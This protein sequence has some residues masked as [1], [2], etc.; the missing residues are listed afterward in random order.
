MGG[1]SFPAHCRTGS[2]YHSPPPPQKK[3]YFIGTCFLGDH[4]KVRLFWS[5][6]ESCLRT[7]L[8]YFD[9]KRAFSKTSFWRPR[10]TPQ[11]ASLP[12]A[13]LWLQP[14]RQVPRERQR[15]RKTL[16]IVHAQF[17][18]SRAV[19]KRTPTSL[20]CSSAKDLPLVYLIFS[21]PSC[22]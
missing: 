1:T 20:Y 8:F 13:R 21:L 5:L 4:W 12:L 19:D 3:I 7:L 11:G 22:L 10:T 9:K 2:I 14:C 6:T 17:L 18:E 15:D 16:G